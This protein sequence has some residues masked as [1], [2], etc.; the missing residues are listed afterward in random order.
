MRSGEFINEGNYDNLNIALTEKGGEDVI[1]LLGKNLANQIAAGEVVDRPAGVIRELCENSVDAHATSVT[2]EIRGGGAALMRVSDNGCGMS[3]RDARVSVLRHAT[4]KLET[5]KDL[6][7]I[8]TMGFRG[9]A[10]AAI[11]SVSKFSILTKRRCDDMGTL[12]TVG[13]SGEPEISEAGAPDGTSVTVEELFYNQPARKKFLKRD[14]TEFSAILTT[15]QRLAVANREVSFKLY[16]EGVLKLSTRAGSTLKE[17]VYSVFG[18]EFASGLTEVNKTTGGITVTGLICTPENARASR[19]M[20][21][22]YINRRP[23]RNKTLYIALEEAYKGYIKSD[24]FP[25]CVI[26]IDMD[27]SVFD[28]NV[29]P[30]KSE[31]RFSDE[32]M[33]YESIYIAVKD[34]LM[35]LI[36]PIAAL[37][38]ENT[39]GHT[40]TI[41]RTFFG[42]G[43]TRT[44]NTAIHS[45][46]ESGNNNDAPSDKSSANVMFKSAVESKGADIGTRITSFPKIKDEGLTL[47]P[48]ITEKKEDIGNK[49]T[50]SSSEPFVLEM[51]KAEL[52]K[53]ADTVSDM[54]SSDAGKVLGESPSEENALTDKQEQSF[55]QPSIFE[56]DDGGEEN[57]FSK[58]RIRGAVFDAFIIYECDDTLYFVDKHAAHERIIYESLKNKVT[59]DG[60]QQLLVPYVV[61][62]NASELNVIS[63]NAKE[64]EDIGISAE[65]FG[66]SELAVRS[67]PSELTGISAEAMNSLMQAI[68]SELEAGG[69]G[70]GKANMVFDRI[71][72][73]MACKAAVKAGIP[74]GAD[75]SEWIIEK[76]SE[77][78]NIIVCPHGRPVMFSVTRSQL[79]KMFFRT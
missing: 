20:Q 18:K 27:P 23:I 74:A 2:V 67:V 69:K 78:P 30:T 61:S 29:H 70:V 22:F 28:V 46:I 65:I 31:V 21:M 76:L 68:A 50:T 57:I 36:N 15:V 48:P 79:E 47:S 44:D 45:F 72:Y 56:K 49:Y 25:S 58:G 17:T 7:S 33:V 51:H 63:E 41:P 13:E 16:N 34:T 1:N 5:V 37:K 24:K 71:L 8:R 55:Y 42:S 53:K 40:I 35:G 39:E 19:S 52:F 3:P 43:N 77:I 38:K 26:F 14:S 12:L 64:L 6:D 73:T 75:E 62:L 59:R 4:S 10:L 9:E 11:S 60:S 54:I 32:R 66:E